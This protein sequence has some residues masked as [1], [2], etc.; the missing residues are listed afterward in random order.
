M[1]ESELQGYQVVIDYSTPT[2]FGTEVLNNTDRRAAEAMLRDW[3]RPAWRR[4]SRSLTL[5]DE[6][7]SVTLSFRWDQITAFRIQPQLEAITS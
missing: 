4:L 2:M 5:V 3:R 7:C 6:C 1:I